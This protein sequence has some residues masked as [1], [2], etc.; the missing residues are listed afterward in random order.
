[1]LLCAD[2]GNSS[3]WKNLGAVSQNLGLV[4]EISGKTCHSHG[5]V[6]VLS[7]EAWDFCSARWEG[8]MS[9]GP[10]RSFFQPR[11]VFFFFF[12]LI[13]FFCFVFVLFLFPNSWLCIPPICPNPTVSPKGSCDLGADNIVSRWELEFGFEIALVE[14]ACPN[15]FASK[16]KHGC[17]C[18]NRFGIPF[19]LVG[20]FTTHFRTYLVG[21]G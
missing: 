6:R 17:G 15:G 18:Q 20:E 13:V 8:S 10:G 7:V 2:S 21:I 14:M 5:K 19:G 12:F 16:T 1:M 11:A 4:S 9:L 3:F